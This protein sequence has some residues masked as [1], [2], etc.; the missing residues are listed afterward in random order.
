MKGLD[1]LG[2]GSKRWPIK[3]TYEVVPRDW[4]I[5]CFFDTFGDV[6]HNLAALYAAGFRT[7]RIHA[8]WDDH[9]KIVPVDVL[10]QKARLIEGFK[11]NHQEATVYLSHSCEYQE[12]ST[13]E[14]NKRVAIVKKLAP[15]CIPVSTPMHSPAIPGT[16]IERHGDTTVNPKQ[17]VSMDGADYR[18]IDWYNWRIK[19]QAAL[20]SFFWFTECNGSLYG[21]PKIPREQRTH[22]PTRKQLIDVVDMMNS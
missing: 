12:S 2:L 7:F 10:L 13:V 6:R 9:H 8:W 16:I 4:A 1:L 11:N 14:I 22:Y 3:D 17:I 5:G 20:I 21:G 15:N 18:D 19:N